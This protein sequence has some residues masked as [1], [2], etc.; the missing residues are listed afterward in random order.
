MGAARAR[1]SA[2]FCPEVVTLLAEQLAA[3]ARYDGAVKEFMAAD[4]SGYQAS[5]SG[6]Q[7]RRAVIR[8][9]PAGP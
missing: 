9:L 6:T 8:R 2:R 4:P 5:S 1:S 7:L 3:V